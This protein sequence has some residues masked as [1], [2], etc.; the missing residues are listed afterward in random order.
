MKDMKLIMEGWRQYSSQRTTIPMVLIENGEII[1]FDLNERLRTLNE[2]NNAEEI[3][4]LFEKWLVQTEAMLNEGVISDFFGN[5]KDK[6]GKLTGKAK[7]FFTEF[8]DNPYL[9]LSLQLWSFLQKIKNVS[10][11]VLAKAAKVLGKINAARKSFEK[12]NPLLYKVLS[13]TAKVAVVFLVV[14]TVQQLTGSGTAQAA[15]KI[16]SKVHD[17]D[18]STMQ[19]IIGEIAKTDPGLA[20]DVAR[21]AQSPETYDVSQLTPAIRDLIQDSHSSVGSLVKDIARFEGYSD[22]ANIRD[23]DISKL[24]QFGETG[25][26]ILNSVSK[27]AESLGDAATATSGTQVNVPMLAQQKLMSLMQV[28]NVEK[29]AQILKDLKGLNVLSPEDYAR[30]V[31]ATKAQDFDTLGELIKLVKAT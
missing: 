13:L 28:D 24:Q 29:A 3:N 15:V 9:T 2:S 4:I 23:A 26:E 27:T 16:G 30:A 8:M 21:L 11:S 31:E 7:Q 18:S 14:Y 22:L 10:I 5:V 6:A 19:A 12:K 25:K 1:C 20:K 17:A